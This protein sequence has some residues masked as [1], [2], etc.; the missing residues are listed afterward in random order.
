M[1]TTLF[2]DLGLTEAQ[3][4]SNYELKCLNKIHKHMPLFA[5]KSNT[6]LGFGGP[7]GMTGSNNC[8]FGSSISHV[9]GLTGTVMLGANI[10]GTNAQSGQILQ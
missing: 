5:D 10:D 4:N 6:L 7:T 2:S 8:F 9:E 1:S 3:I